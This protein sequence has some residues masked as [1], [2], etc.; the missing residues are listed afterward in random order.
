MGRS[1]LAVVV[2]IVVGIALTLATDAL[3]HKVGFFPPLGQRT[4]SGPLALATA[5]RILYAILGSYIV[6]LLAPNRS[7]LHALI[8][9]W[10]GVAANLL[11]LIATWNQN[12]GPHW[13]PIALVVT[14]LPCAWV[15]GKIRMMQ[16][17]NELLREA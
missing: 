8:S 16:L 3:L 17:Q 10:I 5:Y 12:L 14:A 13:Y 6:A 9:G 11:G 4:P 2:G 15:G 7:M 1:I